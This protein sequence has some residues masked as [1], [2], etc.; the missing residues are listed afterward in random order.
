VRPRGYKASD[1]HT[2]FDPRDGRRLSFDDFLHVADQIAK[3]R[4]RAEAYFDRAVARTRE[5]VPQSRKRYWGRRLQATRVD[6]AEK[7]A[8][9]REIDEQL[10]REA[11]RPRRTAK[12]S[13]PVEPRAVEYELNLDYDRR[14]AAHHASE[15]DISIRFWRRD[16]RPIPMRDAWDAVN[17]YR[18]TGQ[19]PPDF[20]IAGVD[21]HG[22]A[23]KRR[24]R[25]KTTMAGPS[26]QADQA[27]ADFFA[28]IHS[29]ERNE[30]DLVPLRLGSVK[31]DG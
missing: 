21:W 27:V 16:Q 12:A 2:W 23:A 19:F 7:N 11:K 15:V 26:A 13:A 17:G 24:G 28:I 6:L 10:S 31:D 9:Y 3:E 5:G 14:L 22:I 20:D 18:A 1:L 4:D 25:P 8:F 30:L 29:V